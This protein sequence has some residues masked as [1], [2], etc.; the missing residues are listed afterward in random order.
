MDGDGLTITGDGFSLTTNSSD[1][2]SLDTVVTE[3]QGIVRGTY[4]Q[5]C[6]LSRA[7]EV[8]GERWGMLVV[9]DL[10]T[11]PKSALE[12]HQGLP[13]VPLNLLT[14]RIREMA[15]CGV[16][17]KSG[18]IDEDGHE[19]YQLTRYGRRLEDVL[20]AFGR[21]GSAMLAEPRPEDIVT[22]DSL[23]VAMR[24]TFLRDAAIGRSARYELR[25]DEIVIHVVVEDGHLE[26]G[27]GP[28]AGA[29]V[30]EPGHTMKDL[31]AR[32][33]TV[34]EA[35]AS[36]QV[37]VTG[38]ADTLASFLTMFALPYQPVP[39]RSLV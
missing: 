2:G 24:A 19:Q 22:E 14:M 35:M 26:V 8:V 21:W 30:I 32:V 6:G 12:L 20:L 13:G 11:N 37:H 34:D 1:Q 10:L 3:L 33:M 18:T 38:G 39:Q 9:R 4:G 5:Y 17:E 29:P 27:R 7:I 36:G 25:F 16:L 23:M 31:L 15:F 28:L